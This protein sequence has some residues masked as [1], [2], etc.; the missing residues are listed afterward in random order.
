M[1]R[2]HCKQDHHT[3]KPSTH[4][5]ASPGI[6]NPT[7]AYRHTISNRNSRA[8]THPNENHTGQRQN[9]PNHPHRI[10]NH[11]LASYLLRQ[12]PLSLYRG[13][14]GANRTPVY[15]YVLATTRATSPGCHCL[16]Q[17]RRNKIPGFHLHTARYTRTVGVC[18]SHPW[19][20]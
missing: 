14:Q 3:S 2:N 6:T 18:L 1:W 4:F 17:A 11:L 12:C 19:S 13:Q 10:P 20:L 7:S 5:N 9:G 15:D 8:S 16:T